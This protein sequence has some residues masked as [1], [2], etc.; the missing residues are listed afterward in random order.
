MGWFIT[1]QEGAGSKQY[2]FCGACGKEYRQKI[3]D[4][5]VDSCDLSAKYNYTL[6]IEVPWEG[7]AKIVCIR[8][9]APDDYQMNTLT[10]LKL[11][12]AHAETECHLGPGDLACIMDLVTHSNK[13]FNA[14]VKD[15]I[16]K[17]TVTIRQPVHYALGP[18]TVD[19]SELLSMK[20]DKIGT[21]QIY[22]DM[23]QAEKNGHFDGEKEIWGPE[24]WDKIIQVLC[25]GLPFKKADWEAPLLRL[26][27]V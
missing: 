1:V 23:A 8:A 16:P 12:I 6:F 13:A 26:L 14:M 17:R 21:Q 7:G 19:G 22:Y 9:K 25:A 4:E 2:W 20:A 10:G 3:T 24:D 11:I 15:K 27:V 18:M 5:D